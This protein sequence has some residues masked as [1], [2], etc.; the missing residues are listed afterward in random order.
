MERW[1]LSV[2]NVAAD[3]GLRMPSAGP[4]SG[5][6]GRTGRHSEDLQILIDEMTSVWRSDPKAKW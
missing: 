4:Q 3:V 6:G 1:Q 5:G 2:Q